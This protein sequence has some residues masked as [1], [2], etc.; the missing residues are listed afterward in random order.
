MLLEQLFLDN[1]GISDVDAD[2]FTDLTSLTLLRLRNNAIETLPAGVFSKLTNLNE[3][4]LENNAISSLDAGIFDGLPLTDLDL[5]DNALTQLPK[6]LF[7]NHPN[8]ETLTSFDISGNPLTTSTHEAYDANGWEITNA[9]WVSD[10]SE[11]GYQLH[12]GHALSSDFGRLTL[13]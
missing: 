13:S 2:W 11:F 12:I 7:L 5:D 4:R 1:T 6:N 8:P 10:G 3:L 9:S